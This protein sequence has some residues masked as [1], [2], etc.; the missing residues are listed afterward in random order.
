MNI[1]LVFKLAWRNLWRNKRR[2]FIT[3]ASVMFAVVLALVMESMNDGSHGQMI[4]NTLRFGTG[5][6]QIQDTAYQETPSL[7]FS[8]DLSDDLQQKLYNSLGED[9]YAIPRIESF[10][11]AAGEMDT[12]GA[13][14]TGIIP[15]LENKM[16]GFLKFVSEGN[17][18]SLEDKGVFIGTGLAKRLSLSLKDTLVIIGQGFQGMQAA[19]K[20][21]VM[22]LV[23]HPMEFIDN[24][25]I[26]MHVE[27][28]AW[29]FSL[30]QNRSN[31]LIMAENDKV[32]KEIKRNFEK[33][34]EGTGLTILHWE[35]LQPDL[36]KALAFDTVSGWVMQFILYVV[37]AFGIF[38]TI[39][40]MT[41]E[42]QKE[43]AILVSLGMKRHILAL[44]CFFETIIISFL[45]VFAGLFIGFPVL[46][47][48]YFNPIP[49]KG[50][51]SDLVKEYGM[52]P[53]LPF[54]LAPSIFLMQ[55]IVM[56]IL[57]LIITAY[58]VWSSFTFQILKN[59][60][61]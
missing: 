17:P 51:L 11:L 54:S 46:L 2:T 12:R 27:E 21:P 6:L 53:F 4:A 45:G 55:G 16:N 36:V 37:I 10:V 29:L 30:E 7:D 23:S 24:Q 14:V 34:L 35:E 8:F 1:S 33:Y 60:R 18:S 5:Y 42:R 22:G 40:T 41:L 58:P 50:G 25:M 59:L 20:Y 56:L 26:Y 38:G 49:L 61:R 39:L 28:A 15:E 47:Y 48:F 19:A 57:S 44:Q 9:A 3:A 43:F 52:E 31:W 32:S 13:M